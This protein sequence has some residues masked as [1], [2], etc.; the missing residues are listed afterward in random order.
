MTEVLEVLHLPKQHGVAQVQVGRGRIESDLDRQRLAVCGRALEL[1]AQLAGADDVDASL[2]QIGQ[3]LVDG[4]A[5][6]SL[7]H[8]SRRDCRTR[9]A[10]RQSATAPTRTRSHRFGIDLV[11]DGEDA[12]R[13]RLRRVVVEHRRPPAAATIGP[14]SSSGVTK[15]TVAPLTFTP[16]SRACRCASTPGNAGSSD[17]WML[18]TRR[19]NA[20]QNSGPSRRMNPARHTSP[21]PRARS[22][23]DERAVVRVARRVLAVR[24]DERLDPRARARSR[25]RQRRRTFE[26]TTAI[27]RA[28]LP[29]VD[30]R[31]RAPAGSIRGPRS[32]PQR[33]GR[34]RFPQT[35]CHGDRSP[36]LL[37][38]RHRPLLL[39]EAPMPRRARSATTATGSSTS[40]IAVPASTR[41]SRAPRDYR[42]FLCDPERGPRRGIRCA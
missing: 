26:M 4:H 5:R 12:R 29:F 16:W 21:T 11:L 24:Q 3:L 27:S 35:R 40:S 10:G 19:G 17:G 7:S 8:A 2:R 41:C 42:A 20:S 1:R 32:A 14:A 22:A 33:G 37:G 9:H 25:A 15:C 6:Q 23:L 36:S 28:Q 30:R 39:A 13:E 34:A 18:R 31:R 38:T